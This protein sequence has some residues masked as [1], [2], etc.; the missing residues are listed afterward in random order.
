ML[1]DA[2]VLDQLAVFKIGA[3]VGAGDFPGVLRYVAV[4]ENGEHNEV[5]L[6][7]LDPLPQRDEFLRHKIAGNSKIEH[8]DALAAKLQ[9]LACP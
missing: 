8:H 3:R 1:A 6:K 5:Q 4:G 2:L 7:R 9:R